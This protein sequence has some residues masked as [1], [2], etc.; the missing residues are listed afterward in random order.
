MKNPNSF[1]WL[2]DGEAAHSTSANG[3]AP[4]HDDIAKLAYELWENRRH[5]ALDGS[6]EQDWYEAEKLLQP[7]ERVLGE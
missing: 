2:V 5:N 6:A 1:D 7:G 4:S 3:S